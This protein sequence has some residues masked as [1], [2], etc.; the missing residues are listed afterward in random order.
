MRLRACVAITCTSV[1]GFM[2]VL[3]LGLKTFRKNPLECMV[4]SCAR[5]KESFSLKVCTVLGAIGIFVPFGMPPAKPANIEIIG[6]PYLN[7]S[8]HIMAY[9]FGFIFT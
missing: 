6:P 7:T 2:K 5:N 4:S 1:A 8:H 3:R 9:R